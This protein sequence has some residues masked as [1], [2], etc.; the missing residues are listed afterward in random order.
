MRLAILGQDPEPTLL[1]SEAA[2][3]TPPRSRRTETWTLFFDTGPDGKSGLICNWT[4]FSRDT[5]PATSA[6]FLLGQKQKLSDSQS[7]SEPAA[8]ADTRRSLSFANSDKYL[9]TAL[10]PTAQPPDS[11]ISA[12]VTFKPQWTQVTRSLVRPRRNPC[13]VGL[14]RDSSTAYCW[15]CLMSDA[16]TVQNTLDCPCLLDKIICVLSAQT[17]QQA[18]VK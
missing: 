11:K 4:R 10:D 6:T 13:H 14:S 15:T 5:H 18:G 3:N 17:P 2:P 16:V 12:S 1:D 8:M 9:M 7:E